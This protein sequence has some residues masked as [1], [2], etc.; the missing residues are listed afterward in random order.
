LRRCCG[1]AH[2]HVD[3]PRYNGHD[4]PWLGVFL[5]H[6]QSFDSINSHKLFLPPQP[7]SLFGPATEAA[8]LLHA[9][10]QSMRGHSLPSERCISQSHATLE[11]GILAG[12]KEL[13]ERLQ[14]P[15]CFL[16]GR[17]LSDRAARAKESHGK[18]YPR[19]VVDH[20][21]GRRVTQED[22][23]VRAWPD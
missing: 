16:A 5:L 17:M 11:R 19:T 21:G 8:P 23:K 18:S 20:R 1:P 13:G 6:P 2:L 22:R 10:A 7:L 9:N 12:D 14:Q 4:Q 3:V 15:V